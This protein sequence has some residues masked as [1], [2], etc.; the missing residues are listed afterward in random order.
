MEI[1][2]EIS[3]DGTTFTTK[4]VVDGHEGIGIG[5]KIKNEVPGDAF[6]VALLKLEE[7]GFEYAWFA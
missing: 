5:H 3:P 4:V 6:G 1:P 7:D 2:I